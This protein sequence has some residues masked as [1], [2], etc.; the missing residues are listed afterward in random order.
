MRV[1]PEAPYCVVWEITLACNLNCLHCGSSAGF[2]REVE[3]SAEEALSLC[4]QLGALGTRRLTLSGG[5]PLLREDWFEIAKR[6]N[7]NRIL[8]YFV[9]NGYLVPENIDRLKG[10]KIGQVAVSVDGT[11]ETHNKIRG[12]KDSYQKVMQAFDALRWAGIKRGAISSISRWNIAELEK[13]YERLKEI[14]VNNWQIQMTFEGGRMRQYKD[15]LLKPE[16]ILR[17]AEFIVRKST[18]RTLRVY[19]AD[20]IGY[21]TSWEPYL[22]MAPWDGCA[23]G[24]R[25]LGIESNGNIKGCLSL[26]PEIKEN[27]TNPFV[28]GNIRERS[29][30]EIWND[31][32]KFSYNR[33]FDLDKVEGFCR[34]CKHIERCRC[35]CTGL[36]LSTTGTKYANPFCL[37]RLAVEMEERSQMSCHPT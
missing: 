22:R 20:D 18:D 11:E 1:P 4:D 17:I 10:L 5:E 7:K 29:L 8:V 6:L 36:A 24:I 31:P 26:F 28:E 32:D 12:S 16:D 37:H 34:I 2:K 23:A 30:A 33:N 21:Y 35:G 19:P 15:Q 13:I 3:L 9:T 14:G 27:E 25:G